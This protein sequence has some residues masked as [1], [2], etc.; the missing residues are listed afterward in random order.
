MARVKE[1]LRLDRRVIY[2]LVL[3]ALSVPLLAKYSIRPA[4]MAAAGKLFDAIERFEGGP[5]KIALV[6]LDFGPSTIAENGSQADVVI[7]HLLRRRIPFAVVSLLAESAALLN[8]IPDKA[9][10]RLMR[11]NPGQHWQYGTDWVNLGY[12]AG[13]YIAIQSM[14]KVDDLKTVFK[15]DVRGNNLADLPAI[16]QV[17]SIRD[18]GILVEITGSPGTFESYVQFFQTADYRPLFG[19]GCTSI[20]TPQSYIYLDSGQ[21]H[22]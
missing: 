9:A 11:E 19:H 14:A 4:R 22:G 15:K 6:S 21:L 16:A 18:I 12:L 1:S 5:R 17:Q 2:L 8:E 10:R 7:E 20:M 3:L 13:G